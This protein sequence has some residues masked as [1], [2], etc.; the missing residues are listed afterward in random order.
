MHS[1]AVQ[2]RCYATQARMIAMKR[3]LVANAL[4]ARAERERQIIRS[5]SS[6]PDSSICSSRSSS[7]SSSSTRPRTSS[8]V[9][10][11]LRFGDSESDDEEVD[12]KPI[13]R[14]RDGVE[15]IKMAN[16]FDQPPFII[17]RGGPHRVAESRQRSQPYVIPVR[18]KD[19]R[20]L[21]SVRHK[22][23]NPLLTTF[24]Y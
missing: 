4:A 12:D 16:Y 14:L 23:I 21:P 2:V 8:V 9:Q 11:R 6:S 22:D 20:P 1:Q 15:R 10:R 3:A 17:S 13:Q 5:T 19:S 24:G 7:S 18:S